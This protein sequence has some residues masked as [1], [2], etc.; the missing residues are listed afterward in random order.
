MKLVKWWENCDSCN[1][2]YEKY[3]VQCLFN[4]FTTTNRVRYIR[5][6]VRSISHYSFYFAKKLMSKLNQDRF[7]FSR[8]I[9]IGINFIS[10]IRHMTYKHYRKKPLSM[11]EV[12]INQI[13]S[14]IPNL[15]NYLNWNTSHPNIGICS[16]IP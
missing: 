7:C 5:I 14:K 1:R 15:L 2:N 6:N 16:H 3:E 8:I 12:K 13:V 4:S 11:C 10:F 9:E